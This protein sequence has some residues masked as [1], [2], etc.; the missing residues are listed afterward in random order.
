MSRRRTV[1][2]GRDNRSTPQMV[3]SQAFIAAAP[4]G[5]LPTQAAFSAKSSANRLN[6]PTFNLTT[7]CSTY[8][9]AITFSHPPRDPQ[10]PMSRPAL[11][12]LLSSWSHEASIEAGLVTPH[13]VRT[14][15][16][17]GFE[18]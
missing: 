18:K 5:W 1:Q 17:Y 11:A 10:R 8:P 13:G 7:S 12:V 4:D 15:N 2:G 3:A 14:T 16:R 9:R 6:Q